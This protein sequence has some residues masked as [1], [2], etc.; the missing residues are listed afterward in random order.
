MKYVKGLGAVLVLAAAIV[1]K[2]NIV[3][4]KLN[5]VLSLAKPLLVAI[6]LSAALDSASA[7]GAKPHTAGKS[8]RLVAQNVTP[9]TSGAQKVV[10]PLSPAQSSGPAIMP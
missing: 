4:S 6:H 7:V 8:P 1:Y 3:L 2:F 5:S 10:G 9:N